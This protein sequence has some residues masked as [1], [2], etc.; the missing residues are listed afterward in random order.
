MQIFD[1]YGKKQLRST[2]YAV[3]K[4][5]CQWHNRKDELGVLNPF[6]VGA[7]KIQEDVPEN[8]RKYSHA[9]SSDKRVS[10]S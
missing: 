7:N 8:S 10:R 4:N 3:I 1:C 6:N 5:A 9:S 2:P